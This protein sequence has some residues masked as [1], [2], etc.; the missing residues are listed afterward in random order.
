MK[1]IYFLECENLKSASTKGPKR[2]QITK[3]DAPVG[4]VD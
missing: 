3:S 2:K 4:N 1:L